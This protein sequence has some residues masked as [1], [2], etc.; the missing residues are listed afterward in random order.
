MSHTQKESSIKKS[1]I[2]KSEIYSKGA[3]LYR[4]K[5]EEIGGG[6]RTDMLAIQNK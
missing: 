2:I 5:I 1:R 6:K 4:A 3:Y